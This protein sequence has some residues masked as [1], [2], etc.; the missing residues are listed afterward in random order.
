MDSVLWD[1]FARLTSFTELQKTH[2]VPIWIVFY[3]TILT[4]GQL[5]RAAKTHRVPIWIVFYGTCLHVLPAAH[6]R[7]KNTEYR[8]RMDSV[9]PELFAR[10]TSFTELQKIHRV[11]IWIVVYFGAVERHEYK[12]PSVLI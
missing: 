11:P 1:L 6:S 10:L 2:R 5:H 7:K 4:S 9:L 8:T 12:V 3:G